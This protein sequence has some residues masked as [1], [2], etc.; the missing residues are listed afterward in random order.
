VREN[1]ERLQVAQM[2]SGTR[3][4]LYLTLRLASLEHMFETSDPLPFIVDDVL[5]N[6]DVNRKRSTLEA[7]ADFSEKTQVIMF[8]HDD[9]V[10]G[11]AK[12]IKNGADRVFLH[13]LTE[14]MA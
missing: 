1:D 8:T 3:D 14:R 4:Q 11:L 2:S 12:S 7:L 10:V 13:E 5:V 9:R 6:F